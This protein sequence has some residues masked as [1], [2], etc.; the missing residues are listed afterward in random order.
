MLG[1]L[2]FVLAV[3]VV[4]NHLWLPTANK[5]GAHAVL[6][7]YVISGF[8]MTRIL[9]E[10]YVGPGGRIRYFANRFLRIFPG[11]WFVAILT[12]AGLA[13]FP[14]H[15][16][17][18]HSAI[19]IPQ[20][21]YEW[22]QNLTLFDLIYA[23]LRLIPP[24]WSLSVELVFYI[25]IG[26]GISRTAGGAWVW[27]LASAGYTAYLVASGVTFGERYTPP[28]AASLFFSTGAVVYHYAKSRRAPPAD[29]LRWWLL[30]AAFC[31]WPIAVEALGWDPHMIGFYGA[32]VLFLPLF[33]WTVRAA[34]SGAGKNGD[35]FLGDLAYPVFLSHFA[36]AGLANLLSGNRLAH[37]S[38]AHFL[39]SLILCLGLAVAMAR[40]L[41]TA[42]NRLRD[43]IRPAS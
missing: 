13:M 43:R 16:G 22:L 11:Y 28:A 26:T 42:V 21:G 8:L 10:V 40:Y 30:L 24:A 25:L 6:G 39:L 9:S 35:R 17:N 12:L 3:L 2:R 18:F 41:D 19:R 1:T 5:V 23:P 7:F 37:Q 33:A 4:M 32:Y 36:A 31:A 38:F 27:W 29:A 14:G 15:F 20:S 34:P